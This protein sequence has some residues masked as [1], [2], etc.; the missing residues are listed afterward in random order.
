MIIIYIIIGIALLIFI[1]SSIAPKSYKVERKVTINRPVHE[2][3][4]Y[5]RFIR[6][7]D[8]WSKWNRL[9]PKMKKT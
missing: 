7:Q 2:V 3:Y 4:E 5:L 9:D 8:Q 1:L 6:N